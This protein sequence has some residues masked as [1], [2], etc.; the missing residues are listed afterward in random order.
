[1]RLIGL[2]N[3]ERIVTK[4]VDQIEYDLTSQIELAYSQSLERLRSSRASIEAEYNRIVENARKQAENIKRQ[5]VGSNRL[6]VRNKQLMLVEDAVNN[7]FK[8]TIARI[9]SIRSDESY[10]S[11]MRRLIE[12]ALNAIGVDAVIECNDKDRDLVDRI[13]LEV[14]HKYNFNIMLGN[15]IECLGGVRV[16]SL[17]GSVSIDN[18]LDTRI[19]RFKPILKKDIAKMFMV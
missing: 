13:I 16:N 5:I 19:E 6:M 10:E 17:D 11:M 18:T 7:V 15:G 8:S 14:Q 3:L 4:V 2:D 9:D 1:M 12:D